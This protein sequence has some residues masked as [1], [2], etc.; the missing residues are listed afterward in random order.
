MTGKKKE[1]L[2][3]EDAFKRLETIVEKL[4][5]GESSLDE[6]IRVFEEG[7]ALSDICSK[8]LNKAE[9]KLKKLIKDKEGQ[10]NI[11]ETE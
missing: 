1:E 10:F 2:N 4:E 8:K 3:F 7:M 11:E 6:S 9:S 5:I